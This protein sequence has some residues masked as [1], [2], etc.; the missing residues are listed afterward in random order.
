VDGEPFLVYAGDTYVISKENAHIRRLLQA[1]ETYK[2]CATVTLKEIGDH[3]KLYRCAKVEADDAE[4]DWDGVFLIHDQQ[5]TIKS[6]SMEKIS[7]TEIFNKI[8]Q[9]A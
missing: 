7:I 9:I 4:H 1:H 8:V 6:K 2:P 3:K 5:E